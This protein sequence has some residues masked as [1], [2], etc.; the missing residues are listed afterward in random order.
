MEPT[1]GERLARIETLLES[2]VT[3]MEKDIAVLRDFRETVLQ[4]IAWVTG[5]FSLV[6]F[7][8]QF[9]L[10][11]LMEHIQIIGKS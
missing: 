3:S 1:I 9:L 4:R 5:A 6:L 10:K 7:G 8:L 11:Y 2:K